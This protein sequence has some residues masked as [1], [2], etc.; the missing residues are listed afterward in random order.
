MQKPSEILQIIHDGIEAMPKGLKPE[1]LYAPIDYVLS[2]GGKRLRPVLML[3]AYNMYR[4]DVQSVLP[5]ALGVE[6]FHNF[7]LLHDDLMDRAEVRRGQPCVHK[8]WNDNTAVLCGD[9]MLVMA[10]QYMA[11][12]P[13]KYLGEV[14]RIFT[15]TAIEIDEGQQM[16]V[17]FEHRDDVTEAEYMEMIRLKTSVLLA[18]A[19]KI[20]AV[21]G[22]APAEDADSLYSFGEK[23]GLAFQLQDDYLDVYGD[24]NTFGKRIGGDILCNKKTFMLVNA[25]SHATKAQHDDLEMWLSVSEGR[26]EE[27]VAAVTNIFTEVG[28]DKMALDRINDYFAE[29]GQALAK[30]NLPSERKQLLWDYAMHLLG[31][32]S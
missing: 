7:T 16:D 8:K 2:L 11:K 9:N 12:C 18:C 15:Q 30:V 13:E 26:E 4:D 21:L 5:T 3:M 32:Q 23:L 29:A 28:V 24:F 6:I 20:G 27:K 1:G 31:R 25:L 22:D 19:L 17:D 10:F 14:L